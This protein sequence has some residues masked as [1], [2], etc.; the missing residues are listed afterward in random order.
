MNNPVFIRRFAEERLLEALDDS[1]V[2]LIHGP[3]Q[4]GK[5][6]LAQMVGKTINATYISFDD[7]ALAQAA[8]SDPLGFVSD[9]PNPSILDEVQ[10]VPEIFSAI[11]LVVDRDRVPGRFILTGSSNILLLPKLSDSLAGRM[12]IQRLHPF[13]QSELRGTPSDFIDKLF[14]PTYKIETRPRLAN[15]LVK[16]VFAGGYP[17]ALIR[18]KEH[19]RQAWYNDYIQTIIQRDMGQIAEINQLEALPQLLKM[20]ASHTSQLINIS[21]LAAPFQLSRPTIRNYMTLLSNVFLLEELPPWHSNRLKRLIKTPK[22]HMGDSGLLVAIQGMTEDGLREDRKFFGQALETF[23][24]Q[25]L[26]RQASWQEYPIDFYH[27]RDKDKAEVDIV[28]QQGEQRIAGIEVKASAT[29]TNSDFRGLR[30]LQASAGKYFKTGAV[31]YDGEATVPFGKGL[32]AIP[33]RR[34]WEG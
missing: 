9:L 8:K 27:Y 30:K 11:K 33:I 12:D 3:R 4:A 28:L 14:K 34:L 26:R 18:K 1:P 15:E 10:R 17:S 21:D 29:I 19:R 24:F 22:L 6:T 25:E 2:V 5:T 20:A 23:I 32:W 7:P 13:S 16:R 31:L